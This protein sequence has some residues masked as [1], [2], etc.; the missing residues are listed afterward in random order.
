M[1]V[2]ERLKNCARSEQVLKSLGPA[3]E[4]TFGV[5]A[6]QLTPEQAERL[7]ACAPEGK[8]PVTKEQREEAMRQGYEALR[9]QFAAVRE[10]YP[11]R[12][13]ARGAGKPRVHAPCHARRGCQKRLRADTF[14]GASCRRDG[15]RRKTRTR[16]ADGGHAGGLPPPA[17]ERHGPG[18][19]RRICR[20][21]GA[22]VQTD[23]RGTEGAG[24]TGRDRP[25][26]RKGEILMN[27]KQELNLQLFADAGTLVNAS[28]NY[29]NAYSGETSAFPDGG[30]MTAS[31][32]TFYDTELLENAR[33]ELI[34]TQF[35]RKQALP[36]GRGKTVEW[37]KWNTLEDAG[38]L[39]EGVIPT[40]QKF[41]QSAVTQA[42][43][44]YG[45]YVSVS[46]QLELH[47]ID[48]VILGAAE[49]LGASAGTTQD[50]LVR[51]VAAA[52]TNVQYCDKVGTNGA[53]T[54]VTSRAGL[55]TTA[56]LTP[57]EVNKAVTLLKKLKAPKIDGKYIAIIHPSVAYD[58]RSSEAWIEAHKYA[59]LTELFTGE[60]GEL[61]GVRF[62]ETTEAKIFN[63]EGCPVKTAADE[64]KGTPAEYYSVY[65]TLF[66]GKDAYGMIDPEGGNLEMIIKDKGQ[67]GGPLNQF[68]TLGYKFSS[69]AKILYE[70]RMVRVESCGAYSAEDEAN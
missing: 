2:R 38:A 58:L 52:G 42:I 30:G 41:G 24:Q 11:R 19:G 5:D 56:K 64:S 67:V 21:S 45:T 22:L 20:E 3:L 15:I 31:M 51:N 37:R 59:G 39:T 28:G 47:A 36:A 26:L 16:G 1:I 66:L 53:H 23:E 10:A 9:E 70:D 13:A 40:G 43:T 8:V 17:R 57:D 50:K 12:A 14:T 61:H 32:K 44:Q 55:D 4:K 49:E 29:V 25:A 54:A 62:I 65:A 68:S 27:L 60:I 34:H 35:A 69:A 6:A 46:D 7:A 63:G 48:D 18:S 33:P